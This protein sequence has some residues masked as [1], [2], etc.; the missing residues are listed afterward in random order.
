MEQMLQEA[1][2]NEFYQLVSSKKVEENKSLLLQNKR[3]VPE[4]V[5][6][7]L[8]DLRSHFPKKL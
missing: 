7:L 8:S 1:L 5:E 4:A 2:W 6:E 3:T